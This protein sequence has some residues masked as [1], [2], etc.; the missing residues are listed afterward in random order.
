MFQTARLK[1]KQSMCSLEVS[2]LAA[3]SVQQ[4]ANQL[5]APMSRLHELPYHTA[6]TASVLDTKH[7][8]KHL[9]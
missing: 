4:L 5:Y 8:A 9:A 1:V 2:G 3:L 6:V 7:L